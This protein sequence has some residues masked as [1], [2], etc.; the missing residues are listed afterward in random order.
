MP[1][2]SSDL[3]GGSLTVMGIAI[4]EFLLNTGAWIVKSYFD[5]VTEAY[6]SK[7]V[8]TEFDQEAFDFDADIAIRNGT[9]C[10]ASTVTVK[11]SI[12]AAA[13]SFGLV[14]YMGNF[15]MAVTL[16]HGAA[17]KNNIF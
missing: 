16:A 14:E 7:L 5:P 4:N 17:A 8:V 11:K 1:Y 12:S 13:E 3:N 9:N 2:S 10:S 6:I 15:T